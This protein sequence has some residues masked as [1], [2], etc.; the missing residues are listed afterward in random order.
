MGE[1]TASSSKDG[2]MFFMGPVFRSPG[3]TGYVVALA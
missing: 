3:K 2:S 1:P